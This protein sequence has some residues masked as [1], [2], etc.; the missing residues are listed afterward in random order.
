MLKALQA[1]LLT[2]ILKNVA[3]SQRLKPEPDLSPKC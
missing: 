3:Q 2:K 1:H